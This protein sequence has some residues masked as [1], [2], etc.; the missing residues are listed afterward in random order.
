MGFILANIVY[1][2]H[3]SNI[4]TR[5]KTEPKIIKDFKKIYS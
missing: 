5:I 3:Y 2:M 1:Y 4:A